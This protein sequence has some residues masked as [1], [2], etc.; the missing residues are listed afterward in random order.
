MLGRLAD[1]FRLVWGLPYWNTRKAW[2]QLRHGRSRCPCQNPSDSGRAFETHCDACLHWDRP[3]RFVRVCP[4]L[5]QTKNGLRCAANTADVRPF[6][7]QLV[8]YY[9]GTLAALYLAGA[10]GVFVFLR[11]VGYPVSIVHVTWPGLWYRVPQARSW[12]Y[13]EKS[14]RA[15]AAGQTSEGLLYLATAYEFDPAN[16]GLGL[17]LAKNY[18][19]GQ[20]RASDQIFQRLR[21][22]HRAQ[23]DLTA[24]E[25]FRALLARGDFDKIAELTHDEALADPTHANVWMRALLFAT[26][27]TRD[28]APLHALLAD[29]SPA[30]SPWHQL[31]EIELLVRADRRREARAALDRLWPASAPAF[32]L[33]YRITLLT[34]LGDTLAAQ[35]LLVRDSGRLDLEARRTLRLEALAAAGATQL[36]QREIDALLGPRLTLALI[37]DLCAH[38]IRR[39]NQEIF[40]QLCAKVERDQLAL[41]TESAGI[42]FTLLCTAGAIGDHTRLHAFVVSLKQASNTPFLALNAIESF[43]RS[44]RT[45]RRATGFLPILPLE[46][47]YAL[48]ERFSGPARTPAPA[49]KP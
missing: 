33:F 47:N 11:I 41:N 28:D 44:D 35:D 15:F 22:D 38:L 19:A 43:F 49:K 25:L 45:T 9:G 30:A 36:L 46:I 20:P 7:G 26:R 2:F 5:I 8:R 40:A 42:W 31:I 14:Q 21:R 18:Q 6:W 4:L 34:A 27:Q 37:K 10:L 1:F 39:P 17:T 32:T 12:F 48:I 13:A 16:Y 23:R 24:Q 29:Q 3:V